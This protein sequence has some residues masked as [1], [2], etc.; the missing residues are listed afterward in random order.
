MRR[1]CAD[2]GVL[3]SYLKLYEAVGGDRDAFYGRLNEPGGVR[4]EVV[5][6]GREYIISFPECG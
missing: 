3:Q 2:T 1:K 6:S 5:V 4:G